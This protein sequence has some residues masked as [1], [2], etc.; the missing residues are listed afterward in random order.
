MEK[1]QPVYT[2]FIEE[3]VQLLK[4]RLAQYHSHNGGVARFVNNLILAPHTLEDSYNHEIRNA[5][6]NL[7]NLNEYL[8]ANTPLQTEVTGVFFEGE[9]FN[10]SYNITICIETKND[11]LEEYE[12]IELVVGKNG[13]TELFCNYDG[14]LFTELS[15]EVWSELLKEVRGA[16]SFG[17]LTM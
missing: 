1:H 13:C 2:Q 17:T 6:I 14:D 7:T 3:Y 16:I 15:D 10:L 11:S 8:N 4:M 9:E 12:F 5:W